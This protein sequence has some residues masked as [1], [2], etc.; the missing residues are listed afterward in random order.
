MKLK[1]IKLFEEIMSKKRSDNYWYR[2]VKNIDI[3][4]GL[5]LHT[6]R[7]DTETESIWF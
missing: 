6:S 4:T 1:H 5:Q 2:G 3:H 7:Y